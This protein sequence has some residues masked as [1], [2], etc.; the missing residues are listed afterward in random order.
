[1]TPDP[2]GTSGPTEFNVQG[3]MVTSR[4]SARMAPGA[5]GSDYRVKARANTPTAPN[6][7]VTI[8][9]SVTS[10]SLRQPR[11]AERTTTINAPV[12]NP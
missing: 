6:A 9:A 3:N 4:P 12:R 5:T 1:M 11:S 10:Q 2:L 8:R 7:P